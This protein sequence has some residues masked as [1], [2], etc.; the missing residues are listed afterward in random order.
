M[1]T[2]RHFAQTLLAGAGMALLTGCEVY[3]RPARYGPY[4]YIYYWDT[5]V[6]YHPYTRVYYYPWNGR[7]RRSAGVP[8]TLLLVPR[9]STRL[10]I[11]DQLPYANNA[12]HRRT[13]R[14]PAARSAVRDARVN[15]APS[16]TQQTAPSD[17]SDKRPWED[18]KDYHARKAAEAAEQE[19]QQTRPRTPSAPRDGA[20]KRPDESW[21]DYHARKRREAQ[22]G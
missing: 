22:D 14:P 19:R 17:T 7:W 12:V 13:Y 8:R 15:R 4:D 5:D 11:R 10:V 1:T 20:D 18:W 2:R 3:D 21:E 9:N 6:Y 16:Q